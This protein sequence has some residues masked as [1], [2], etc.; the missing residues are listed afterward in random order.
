[1][2]STKTFSVDVCVYNK[3]L[4]KSK[5]NRISLSS[6]VNALMTN[7]LKEMEGKSNEEAF[8]YLSRILLQSFDD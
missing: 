2:K 6:L 3:L 5:R 8:I 1:M 7:C 4:E